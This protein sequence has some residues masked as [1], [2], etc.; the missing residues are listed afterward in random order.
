[1]HF[2]RAASYAVRLSVTQVKN[3][4]KNMIALFYR[5]E[6]HSLRNVI[7]INLKVINLLLPVLHA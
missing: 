6:V 7:A 4:Q 3:I 1:M 2:T 5:L